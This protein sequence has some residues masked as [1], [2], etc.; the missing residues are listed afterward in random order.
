MKIV[1]IAVVAL[2]LLG[3]GGAAY[4]FLLHEEADPEAAAEAEFVPPIFVTVEPITVPIIRD[5]QLSHHVQVDITLE[6]SN[7]EARA[8]VVEEMPRLRDAFIAQLHALLPLRRGTEEGF[9]ADYYKP[10]L[11]Q[12]SERIV[13]PGQVQ[14]ILIQGIFENEQ[15]G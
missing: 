3:G 10:R 13:G 6:V 9:R 8:L 7:E 2:A 12:V 11:M 4:W 15:A 14:A 1:L 5:G